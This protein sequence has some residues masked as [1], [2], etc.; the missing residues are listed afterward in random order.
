MRILGIYMQ[1]GLRPQRK[2]RCVKFAILTWGSYQKHVLTLRVLLFRTKCILCNGHNAN[3]G[4]AGHTL[5][6]RSW[7]NTICTWRLYKE[8]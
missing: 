8:L 2:Y 3:A 4:S 1:A 7:G 6:L 5:E